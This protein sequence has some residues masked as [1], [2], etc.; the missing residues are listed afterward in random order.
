MGLTRASHS[1]RSYTG[2][3]EIRDMIARTAFTQL[4]YSTS[5]LLGALLGLALTFLVPIALTFAPQTKIWFPALLAWC[6][7][8][9]SF[10]PTVTF[11]RLSPVW[12]LLIPL[13]AIFYSYSTLLSAI[14]YRLGRGGQWKGRAQARGTKG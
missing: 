13:A 8:T 7:M 10:L 14:R 3:A 6:F 11:Y 5:R 12:A 2:F 4:G 1:L 9:A